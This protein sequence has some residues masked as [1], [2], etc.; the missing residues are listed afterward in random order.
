[1]S[2]KI[3]ALNTEDSSPYRSPE[4]E[5]AAQIGRSTDARSTSMIELSI[6]GAEHPGTVRLGAVA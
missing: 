4:A 3:G 2:T 6:D 5:A 1:M